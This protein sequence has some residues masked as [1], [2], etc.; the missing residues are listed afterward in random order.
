MRDPYLRFKVRLRLLR[1]TLTIENES[2]C[3][4]QQPAKMWSGRFREPLDSTFES[5]QRSFPFDWR[6][7]PYEVEASIAHA[8]AIEA[9]GI[10]T[11]EE[12]LQMEEGLRAVAKLASRTRRGHRNR[13]HP[14][15]RRPPLR[16][17]RTHQTNRRPRPQAPHRPQPQRADRHRHAPLRPRS[18]RQHPRRPHRMA[19]S[20]HRPRRITQAKP[21]CPPTPT[22]SAPNPSS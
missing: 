6:L 13:Q 9:A 3:R 1:I 18:H 20:P 2:Q 17:T 15:R 10:L 21:P 22:S 4:I 5:W 14:G 7:V 16:R 12:L 8:R 11:S 19:Q